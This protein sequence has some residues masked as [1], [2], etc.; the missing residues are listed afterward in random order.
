MCVIIYSPLS[1]HLSPH[2]CSDV[3]QPCIHASGTVCSYCKSPQLD[4]HIHLYLLALRPSHT[5]SSLLHPSI[6][7]LTSSLS[8]PLRLLLLILVKRRTK[9]ANSACQRQI[10]NPQQ[11]TYELNWRGARLI[12]PGPPNPVVRGNFQPPP[13]RPRLFQMA[14]GHLTRLIG[15][16][17]GQVCWE[18]IVASY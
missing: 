4:P 1:P 7:L 18:K 10:T 8:L 9:C 14:R 12:F 2:L 11:Q 16:G 15:R 17:S 3:W 6:S 13:R 5:L